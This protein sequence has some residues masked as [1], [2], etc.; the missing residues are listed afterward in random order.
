LQTAGRSM[1]LSSPAVCVIIID[2]RLAA[3][4]FLYSALLPGI[5]FAQDWKQVHKKDDEKWAK[6]TGLDP[7]TVHKIWKLASTA[8]NEKGDES[9]IANLDLEG[10]AERHD[11]LL[12]TY[13]GEKN[14]LTLTVFRQLS[15]TKFEKV[16]SVQQP[17]DGTGFCD[18]D[19]GGAEAEAA[20]GVITVRVPHS[21]SDGAI[22]SLVYGYE[23]NGITYRF[24]G[25]R[26]VPG[27]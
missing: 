4:I 16:W 25:Q 9:R 19:L 11:V 12:V 1:S 15:G 8:D 6:A 7:W 20:N 3:A 24:A 10:L 22:N 21:A 26:E 13:A 27:R 23:W 2:M 5:A 18:T 14:C 17:P